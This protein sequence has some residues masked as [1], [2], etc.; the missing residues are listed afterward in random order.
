MLQPAG[1]PGLEQEPRLAGRVVRVM[2]PQLLHRDLAIE[3]RVDREEDLA[4]PPARER[5]T[6]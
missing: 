3:L 1:Q 2:I 5:R 6:I 4:Q